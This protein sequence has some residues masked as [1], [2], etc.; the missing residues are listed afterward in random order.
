MVHEVDMYTTLV[1]MTVVEI[2]EIG[3]LMAWTD[4]FPFPQARVV[5][6]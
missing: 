4:R 3:L 6:S 2:P 5:S 1:L